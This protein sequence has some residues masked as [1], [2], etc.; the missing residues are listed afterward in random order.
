MIKYFLLSCILLL[1]A[2]TYSITMVH[3][4]GEATDVVDETATNTP[5]TS[6]S[7]TISIPATAL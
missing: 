6:V 3:T 5:S 2:C 1:S 4:Q 7:P